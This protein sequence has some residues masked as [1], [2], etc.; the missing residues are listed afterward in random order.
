VLRV[1][2]RCAELL[3]DLQNLPKSDTEAPRVLSLKEFD[4]PEPSLPSAV[5][6]CNPSNWSLLASN[7]SFVLKSSISSSISSSTSSYSPPSWTM[8]SSSSTIHR[9]L[10]TLFALPRLGLPLCDLTFTD[11]NVLSTARLK[12]SSLIIRSGVTLGFCAS[13]LCR[14]QCPTSTLVVSIAFLMPSC[15]R[16]SLRYE[17][18]ME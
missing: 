1:L 13:L 2:E 10:Q 17:F 8:S 11:V 5:D 4:I 16:L 6:S 9:S 7:E 15:F 12:A 14:E 3:L 18:E